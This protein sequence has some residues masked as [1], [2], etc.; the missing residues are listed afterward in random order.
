M[1]PA[2][3]S[4]VLRELDMPRVC[5]D[6]VM[7]Q[8]RDDDGSKQDALL[9]G[10]M[11]QGRDDDGSKR[12]ALLAGTMRQGRDDDG[13]KRDALLAVTRRLCD[14]DRLSMV[15]GALEAAT[16]GDDGGAMVLGSLSA[17]AVARL[18]ASCKTVMHR[19]G[20]GL[21]HI[22]CVWRHVQAGDG[23]VSPRTRQLLLSAC[24]PRVTSPSGIALVGCC[25]SAC[26][27]AGEVHASSRDMIRGCV[28]E[29]RAFA[30][31]GVAS[32][33]HDD[34][35]EWV[36]WMDS[37]SDE[38]MAGGA[39][40]ADG[41]VHVEAT[42]VRSA[43]EL[44]AAGRGSDGRF[45]RRRG[46]ASVGRLLREIAHVQRVGGVG[47]SE[48]LSRLVTL[49]SHGAEYVPLVARLIDQVWHAGLRRIG[50]DGE[51]RAMYHIVE[52]VSVMQ[53]GK[54]TS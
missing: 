14:E 25:E 29:A 22:G 50:V 46:K 17:S 30:C 49:A 21:R 54:M 24:V 12:D 33:G 39:A 34:M 26:R 35:V 48:L 32:I 36:R 9:A 7:R 42:G 23:D 1:L 45:D 38:A 40:G 8:G 53:N 6:A 15:A 47:E 41:V 44:A 11:R 27:M 4:S 2:E 31:K 10:T 18:R 19:H 51:G 13:S 28:L 20:L 43:V 3:A 16:A 52:Y 37:R 5:P